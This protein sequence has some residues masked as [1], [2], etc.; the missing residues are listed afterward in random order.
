MLMYVFPVIPYV[1][2]SGNINVLV[3][4]GGDGQVWVKIEMKKKK[5]RQP[6]S[7]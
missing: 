3:E 6:Y 1:I 2:I 7:S 4:E 5:K